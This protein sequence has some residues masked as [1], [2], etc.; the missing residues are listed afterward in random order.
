MS[1]FYMNLFCITLQWK[2]DHELKPTGDKNGK[3]ERQMMSQW[4]GYSY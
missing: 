2:E 3:N 1:K 4:T